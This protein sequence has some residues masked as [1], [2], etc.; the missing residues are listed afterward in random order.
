MKVLLTGPPAS[1][2]STVARLLE[3]RGYRVIHEAAE[4]LI[5]SGDYHPALNF[6][7]FQ[8]VLAWAIERDQ[9]RIDPTELVFLD[10]S[11][12]DA[13]PFHWEGGYELPQYLIDYEKSYDFIFLFEPVP[14]QDNGVRWEG[15]ERQNKLFG[16]FKEVYPDHILVKDYGDPEKRVEQIVDILTLDRCICCE[17]DGRG[18]SV[19]GMPCNVHPPKGKCPSCGT[20]TYNNVKCISCLDDLL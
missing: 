6:E 13:I 1:G 14:W 4:R 8:F 11:I 12:A 7:E 17:Y 16:L 15:P 3:A 10:R 19:C 18:L 9:R 20:R 5:K 2:K